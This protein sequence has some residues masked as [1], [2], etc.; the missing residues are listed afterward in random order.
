MLEESTSFSNL[1][2]SALT[3]SFFS[4]ILESYAS[5]KPFNS[6][7]FASFNIGTN[8]PSAL[9]NSISS[10][11]GFCDILKL[12]FFTLNVSL[13]SFLP[14]ASNKDFVQYSGELLTFIFPDKETLLVFLI[15]SSDSLIL[16]N[17][18]VILLLFCL[19]N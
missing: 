17:S 6:V 18:P 7:S 1:S 14:F 12:L 2:I 13:I 3:A 4:N 10:I 15:S 16:S 8:V 11:F 19:S 9:F 5:N